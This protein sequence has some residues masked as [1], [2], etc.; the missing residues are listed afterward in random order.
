MYRPQF[1]YSSPVAWSDWRSISLERAN[2][3]GYKYFSEI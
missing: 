3:F 1:V 2:F